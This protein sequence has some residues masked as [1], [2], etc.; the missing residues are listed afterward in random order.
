MSAKNAFDKEELFDNI[1]IENWIMP[2]V[3]AKNLDRLCWIRPPWAKQIPNGHYTFN[4]GEYQGVIRTDSTLEYFISDGCYQKTESLEN[5][6]PLD[7]KVSEIHDF[8]EETEEIYILDIDLDYFSTHNPFKNIYEKAQV[9]DKLKEIFISPELENFD[10]KNLE[11]LHEIAQKRDKKLDFLEVVFNYLDRFNNLE[12]FLTDYELI[13]EEEYF[14]GL[15]EKVE[16]LSKNILKTYTDEK[17]DWH[18]VFDAGCTCDVIEL[19]HHETPKEE[20]EKMIK[21]F[22]KFLQKSNSPTIITISRSSQDDYTPETQVEMIQEM[23]LNALNNMYGDKMD[24]PILYYQ[25]D[26]LL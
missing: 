22:E 9:Y 11:Q 13:E 10:L 4:V 23:V 1:S 26:E 8:A 18:L 25:N 19:P 17:I 5:K 14:K 3:Y 7:L 6:S 20:I 16:E 12:N 21:D 24:K 2:A 15:F